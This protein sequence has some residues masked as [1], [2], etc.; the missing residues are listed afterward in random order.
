MVD[1]YVVTDVKAKLKKIADIRNGYQFRGRV[2]P[3]EL[4]PDVVSVLPDGV[5]QVIQIKDIN[6]DRRLSTQGLVT[7]QIDA[8]PERYETRQGDVLFLARGQRL[9]AT[10]IT[11]PLH[12][13]VATGYFFILRP[14]SEN[15]R[16][17][18]L[19]WYINQPRFQAT[20]RSFMKGTHQPLV[21]RKDV[22]DLPIELP[23]LETQERI[24][25]LEELRLK[26]QH[27]LSAIREKR[28]QLLLA[29][30]MKAACGKRET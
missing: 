2:T 12:A 30:G 26:E 24:V 11:E 14:R 8:D 20:L 23:S 29:V 27:L 4:E 17:E 18:Y 15:V 16:S 9:F 13:T 5:V 21:S 7:V 3:A 10:A 28:S 1:S 22:E 6:D 19:A 25:A